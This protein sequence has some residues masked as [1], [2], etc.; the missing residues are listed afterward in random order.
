MLCPVN[1]Q[2]L[3]TKVRLNRRIILQMST[4]SEYIQGF[5]EREGLN[6]SEFARKA[7]L[8]TGYVSNVLNDVRKPGPDFCRGAAKALG[9]PQTDMFR[10]A[11][12]IT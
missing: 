8:D 7:G 10:A 11:G 2:F 4:F 1:S 6:R 9:L 12:L 3:L 5:L